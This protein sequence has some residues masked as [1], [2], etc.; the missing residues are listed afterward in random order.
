MKDIFIDTQ[1]AKVFASAEDVNYINLINWL[2]T[3]DANHPED[4]AYLVVSAKIVS[5]Y[6]RSNMH[7][8]KGKSIAA[9]YNRLMADDRLN[10][11][12]N[13]QIR[14][15]KRG[16]DFRRFNFTCNNE[17]RQHLPV[18][19]LSNRKMALSRDGDFYNDISNFRYEGIAAIVRRRPQDLHYK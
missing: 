3:K 1:I 5:E 8:D 7:C 14:E 16:R 19:F 12:S 4:N 10:P 15:F 17:D 13:N 9:I 2:I 11:I 18:I 6:L